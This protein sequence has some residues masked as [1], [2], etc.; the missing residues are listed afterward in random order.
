MKEFQEALSNWIAQANAPEGTLPDGVSP[1]AWVAVHV[2]AWWR[3]QVQEDVEAIETAAQAIRKEL[4][5][6]GGW[7][8]KELE[9]VM[10][11]FIH[12][13]D[14]LADLRGHLGLTS[15]SNEKGSQ[16]SLAAD[17]DDAASEG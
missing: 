10:H 5:A 11:Q 16:K 12:L 4:D 13:N 6:L 9:E 14:N 15:E 17:G 1:S 8:K 2:A 7:K 3:E